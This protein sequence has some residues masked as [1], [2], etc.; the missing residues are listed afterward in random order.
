MKLISSV[1][2]ILLV[3]SVTT[4]IAQGKNSSKHGKVSVE[5]FTLPASSVID[6]NTNAVILTDLGITDF[7]GN[8]NGW[9]N[10]IFKRRTR[11]KILNKKAFELATF[12]IPLYIHDEDQE[13]LSD[14]SATTYNLENGQL[15]ETK[16]GKNDLFAV[17]RDKNHIDQKFTMPSVKEGSIIEYAYT[18]N[19]PFIF[20]IPSWEFQNI[21]YPCLWSEYQAT[22]PSLL[23][24]AFEKRGIHPYDVDKS[25]DGHA[26]YLVVQPQDDRT[27]RGVRE[28]TLSIN[29][30]TVKRRWA[31][32]DIPAFYVENYL[33][34]PVNYID[35]ISFQLH[36][37]YNGESTKD[38]MPTWKEA[39]E[40]LLKREDFG[41]FMNG[42]ENNAWIGKALTGIVKENRDQLQQAKDIY[43]YIADH[44][45]CTNYY[46][47][48][49]ITTLQDV[50]K[51][52][53]GN[54]G[55]LNLLLTALLQRQH[56]AASPVLLSTREFGYNYPGYPVMDRLNY[57]ICEIKIDGKI[58]YL[59]ASHP[60]LGFGYLP[61]NC[62]NGHA[63]IISR[64]DS[65]SIYFIPDS[66]KE[67]KLTIVNIV[68]DE[69]NKGV[70]SGSFRNQ[71][72]HI[73]SY[74]LRE[75]ITKTGEKKY[76]EDIKNAARGDAE[77]TETRIDSLKEPENPVAVQGTFILKMGDNTDIIY[78]NPILWAGYK[79]NPFAAATR[80]YPVEMVYPMNETYLLN[81]EIP[82]GFVI[83]ELPKM[84]KVV[85]NGGE[86]FFE[87]LLQKT[88]TSIQMRCSL[89]MKKA[90]FD[91]EDYNTLRDF[92]SFIGKK[93]GEQ[94]VFKRKK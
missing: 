20:N 74:A 73:E 68:N 90:N 63:R 46:N 12:K 27:V 15:T 7:E 24:Y 82:E 56:I 69:K 50:F 80:K 28:N 79:T 14:V 37:T 18:I 81:M 94:I 9:F 38:V 8:K 84:A 19:S 39:T 41:A 55:E 85:Y 17:K 6:S 88:E 1:L 29:A 58:F 93:Q 51:K 11:I 36:Q 91:P 83:D 47:R 57:V 52:H 3:C 45:T 86:G 13:I 61:G 10:Y 26:S 23:V 35:K 77:I 33:S 34:S 71:L 42:E 30:N 87:Y 2:V 59:D 78:F 44:F 21:N 64:T 54:V 89:K 5:D 75:T 92:F 40:E 60:N 16:L 48:Y 65:A 32:K 62:Y 25:V 49:I 70:L 4:L 22:I 67:Q 72:G 76:F 66:I 31:M 53:S 43:Y